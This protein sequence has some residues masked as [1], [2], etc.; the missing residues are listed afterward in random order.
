MNYIFHYVGRIFSGLIFW[1]VTNF[2]PYE[3]SC[4]M[5]YNDLLSSQSDKNIHKTKT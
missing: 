3:L 4:E 2:Q 1:E 5:N